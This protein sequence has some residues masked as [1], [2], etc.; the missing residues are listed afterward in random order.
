MNILFLNNIPF[1]PTLGGIERVTD[2]LTKELLKKGYNIFYLSGYV[3][4]IRMLNY[5]FPVTMYTLPEKDFFHSQRNKKYYEEFIQSHQI[6]I[7]INQKGLEANFNESL[8]S[9]LVKKIT[10]LHSK[11]NAYLNLYRK[12]FG[13]KPN[14]LKNY[15]K[16]VIKILIFPYIYYRNRKKALQKLSNQYN[17]ISDHSDAIILLSTKYKEEFLSCNIKRKNIPIYGIHNPNSFSF[18]PI[19]SWKKEKI[20]LYVGRLKSQI[21]HPLRLIKVWE[22]LYHKHPEWELVFVGEGDAKEE[23]L[24]YIE[25]HNIPNVKLEGQKENVITYYQRAQFICLTS[26]FEGWGMS[27]TEGMIFG[28]IPF[29]FNCFKAA[30]DIIDDG[31]NGCL[32]KPYSITEYATR[33]DIIMK[34]KAICE[35]MSK[36]AHLK[37]Q[38]FDIERI[39]TKWETL[40]KSLKNQA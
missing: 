14:T 11:P 12:V 39:V 40:F 33:L 30:S 28:C 32:I 34:D 22:K 23:M 17:Y 18:Q 21:K 8:R 31:E 4:D 35:K 1:N 16:N 24:K 26:D 15:L 25:K 3:D 37:V 20:I 19:N 7:I 29:T 27:L 10:V 38:N 6:E 13:A 36:A 9:N 2:I 5:Q